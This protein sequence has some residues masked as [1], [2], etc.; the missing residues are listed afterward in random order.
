[1]KATLLT[2]ITAFSMATLLSFGVV[3][4]QDSGKA[5][6]ETK[7][8]TS[9]KMEGMNMEGMDMDHMSG[10]KNDCMKE[11]KNKKMCHDQKMKK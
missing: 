2:F 11:H 3:C 10:M 5:A 1:M 6:E 9:D 4:A 7:S 8:G